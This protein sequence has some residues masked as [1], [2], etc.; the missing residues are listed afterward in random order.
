MMMESHQNSAH[1]LLQQVILE[2]FQPP[3]AMNDTP[4]YIVAYGF[5]SEHT[6]LEKIMRVKYLPRFPEQLTGR[7]AEIDPLGEKRVK[8]FLA[9]WNPGLSPVSN[10]N[11]LSFCLKNNIVT[12]FNDTAHINNRLDMKDPSTAALVTENAPDLVNKH[13]DCCLEPGLKLRNIGMFQKAAAQ[14][15]TTNPG[16]YV[17]AVG[18]W[19]MLG[20]LE[21]SS[22]FED[23]LCAQFKNNGYD[24]LPIFINSTHNDLYDLPPGVLEYLQREGL[25]ITGLTEKTFHLGDHGE[26]KHIEQIAAHSGNEFQ[27]FD[28]AKLRSE[29]QQEMAAKA[30]EWIKE[31]SPVY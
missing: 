31:I 7:T 25:I 23:S 27:V 18:S 28:V 11:L 26:R 14:I 1:K 29:M 6:L 13:I 2:K 12:G 16:V 5:E 19:H 22:K 15:K 17:F 4:S 30:L 21:K 8:A 10:L 9:D 20:S 24:V 3:Q